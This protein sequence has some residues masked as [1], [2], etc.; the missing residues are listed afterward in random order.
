MS[1]AYSIEHVGYGPSGTAAYVVVDRKGEYVYRADGQF[2]LDYA[3]AE[4][5]LR[6]ME[7]AS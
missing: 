1:A 4:V 6:E 3:G 2:L 5:L 7:N